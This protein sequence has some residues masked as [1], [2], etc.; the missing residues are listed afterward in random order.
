MN[1]DAVKVAAKPEFLFTK[2]DSDAAYINI[3]ENLN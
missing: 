1:F 2:S 3:Y